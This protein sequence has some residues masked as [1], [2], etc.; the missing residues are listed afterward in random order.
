VVRG[1]SGAYGPEASPKAIDADLEARRHGPCP[2]AHV[3]ESF[4][5]SAGYQCF[6]E[7]FND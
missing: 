3:V 6:A 1:V 7:C 5:A 2:A 4:H